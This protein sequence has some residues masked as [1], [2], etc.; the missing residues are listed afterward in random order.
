M[1]KIQRQATK[2]VPAIRHLQHEHRLKIAIYSLTARRLRGDLL[3][4]V[5]LQHYTNINYEILFIL[6]NTTET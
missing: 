2:I 4:T 3:E 6:N 1:E 5:K